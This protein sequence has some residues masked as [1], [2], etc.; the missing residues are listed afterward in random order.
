M[1]QLRS[2]F[3]GPHQTRLNLGAG[4]SRIQDYLSVDLDPN[5]QPDIS[6]QI[7]HLPYRAGSVDEIIAYHVIEHVNYWEA[8]AALAE[9]YRV[10]RP[11]GSIALECP[12]VE[13]LVQ[14]LDS[15]A[16]FTKWSQLGM[17]GI[18]GDPNHKNPFYSHKWGYTPI[19]LAGMLYRA[20]FVN[21]TSTRPTTHVPERDLRLEARKPANWQHPLWTG[22]GSPTSGRVFWFLVGGPEIASSRI[23]GHQIHHYLVSRGWES[24]LLLEPQNSDWIGDIPVTLRGVLR[25]NLFR[26]GDLA[27]FQKV[28]GMNTSA[29]IEHLTGLGVKTL[30]IDCDMPLKLAEAEVALWTICTSAFLTRE[31]RKDGIKRAI[32]LP[33]PV[34]PLTTSPLGRPRNNGRIRCIWFGNWSHER[35]QDVSIVR[36]LLTEPEFE[37]FEL[38]VV[39]NDPAAD[40]RWSYDTIGHELACADI[41]VIPVFANSTQEK[42]KSSNRA[43]QA[44]AAGLP[45]IASDLPAYQEVIENG[46]NGYVCA[47]IEQWR[48]ALRSLRDEVHRQ[49]LADNARAFSTGTASLEVIGA[50]WESFFANITD[51]DSRSASS[52]PGV[53][54]KVAVRRMRAAIYSGVVASDQS[55]ARRLSYL[56]RAWLTWPFSLEVMS[57]TVRF[58]LRGARS[59]FRAMKHS[60]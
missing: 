37:D 11:G 9:W 18:Y 60:P 5:T 2:E 48:G 12:N 8:E 1:A 16:N 7:D 42:A 46:W 58:G 32:Y 54:S 39:S 38:R 35:A 22:G 25:Q 49:T 34:E 40:V 57:A 24:Y 56:L 47:D 26:K 15:S 41:A 36:A 6:A 53:A 13:W 10:L 43:T 31:Y 23:H 55:R 17:W 50:L 14:S 19:T 44:M 59:A 51:A 52:P 30:F 3:S 29:L 45:V 21:V 28:S 20:G 27:V 33:D 4:S